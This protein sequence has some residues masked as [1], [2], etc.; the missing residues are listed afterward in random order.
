MDLTEEIVREYELIYPS[1]KERVNASR[2]EKKQFIERISAGAQN[3][4]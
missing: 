4:D 3:L 1:M 2:E